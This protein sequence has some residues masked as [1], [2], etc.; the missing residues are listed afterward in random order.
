MKEATKIKTA[1]EQS[2]K[3]QAQAAKEIGI[4]INAY[5]QYEYGKV[6]P[7]SKL[8]NRIARTLGTTSEALWGY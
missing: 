4:A 3:T 7:N 6:I 1:R 2:G 5:Q 8:G